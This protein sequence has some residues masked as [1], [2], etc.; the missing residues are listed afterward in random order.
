MVDQD[1]HRRHLPARARQHASG[2]R[3]T[4]QDVSHGCLNLN[5]ANAQWFFTHSLIG[6]PVIDAR[7]EGRAGAAAVAGRRLD[8]ALDAVA[9]GQRALR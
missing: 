2:R 4:A 3:T 9:E 5:A 6:D 1:Q 7:R 8:A